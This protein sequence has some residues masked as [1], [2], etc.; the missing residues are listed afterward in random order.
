ME[1]KIVFVVNFFVSIVL[2]EGSFHNH[3]KVNLNTL[4]LCS[5]ISHKI[6]LRHQMLQDRL[7]TT[8]TLSTSV[9]HPNLSKSRHNKGDKH[10]LFAKVKTRK[11]KPLIHSQHPLST[12]FGITVDVSSTPTHRHTIFKNISQQNQENP[13]L[14]YLVD[15]MTTTTTVTA[16]LDKVASMTTTTIVTASLDNEQ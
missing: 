5:S 10:L 13:T 3:V 7:I 14:W 12:F 11:V 2:L 8:S 4:L 9:P 6:I 15:S 16:S 1:S